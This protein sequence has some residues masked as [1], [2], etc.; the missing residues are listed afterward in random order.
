MLKGEPLLSPKKIGT[1]GANTFPTT[2]KTVIDEGLLRSKPGHYP[3]KHLQQGNESDH[4][5]VKKNMQRIG[6]FQSFNTARRTCAGFEA[7][8]SL[9][10]DFRFA[11]GWA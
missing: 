1:D 8:L 7:M 4:F 3:T 10:K 11:G 9:K 2:I 6:D 5:R